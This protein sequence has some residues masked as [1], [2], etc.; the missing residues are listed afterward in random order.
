MHR[1]YLRLKD[2]ELTEI[3]RSELARRGLFFD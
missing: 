1:D 3:T 2:D